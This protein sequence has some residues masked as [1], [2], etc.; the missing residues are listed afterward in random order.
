MKSEFKTDSG[1]LTS[2]L[3]AITKKENVVFT[4]TERG[5][6]AGHGLT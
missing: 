6:G 1:D 2:R 4:H 5:R 3:L